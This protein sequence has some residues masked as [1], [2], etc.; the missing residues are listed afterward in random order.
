METVTDKTMSN[1]LLKQFAADV[2]AGLSANPKRLS[3]KYFYDQRGD[4]LFQMIMGM[5]SYYL[6]DCEYEVFS[7]HKQQMLELFSSDTESFRLIEFGAGDGFKTKLL[8]RHFLQQGAL[9]SY[10]PI[11]ISANVLDILCHDLQTEMPELVTEPMAL[12]YFEALKQIPQSQGVRN[13]VLFLGSNMGNFTGDLATD[14]LSKLAAG[15]NRNDMLMVGLDLK[16]DPA[17]ILNAYNDAEGITRAFNLNLLTRMNRELGANFDIDAFQHW[18]IYNPLTGETKSF[19][20]SRKNQEIQINAT[21][22][23]YQLAQWEPIQME[24]SQK[25]DLDMISEMSSAGGFTV[26]Q[27]FYDCKHWFVDSVWSVDA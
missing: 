25:Y 13:V 19:L 23:S 27:H 22:K 3:S 20:I 4:E 1:Q 7:M 16:K 12:E 15:L 14:F 11:D 10:M 8:L 24:L 5:P 9:F 6:T 17:V 26:K 18:P 2:D 21:G